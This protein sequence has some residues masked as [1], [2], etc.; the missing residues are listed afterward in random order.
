[1]SIAGQPC[2]ATVSFRDATGTLI[3]PAEVKFTVTGP[4]IQ[5]V[6]RAGTDA[7]A[8][9]SGTNYTCTFTP[10]RG[11]TWAVDADAYDGGGKSIGAVEVRI[12]VDP[13]V[14]P[15]PAP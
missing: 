4:G 15:I 12:T 2:S 1:M 11:G 3:T 6:Y 13:R 9:V 5:S 7:N 14:A 10:T 8:T